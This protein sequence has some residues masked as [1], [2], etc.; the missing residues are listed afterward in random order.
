MEPD[1]IADVYEISSLEQL[2]TIAD[3]LRMRVMDALTHRAMTVTQLGELLGE[4]PAKMHYHVRGLERVGLVRLVATREKG[5][6]LEKYYRAVARTF[7]TNDMLLRA[8][9]SDEFLA[10]LRSFLERTTESF[11]TATIESLRRYGGDAAKASGGLA[12]AQLWLTPEEGEQFI[13]EIGALMDRYAAPRGIEGEQERTFVWLAYDPRLVA[14]AAE[15]EAQPAQAA[16]RTAR[17]VV[18]GA[19][20]YSRADLEQVLARGERLDLNVVGVC[21]FAADVPPELVDRA[22]A[23]FR[24]RGG[25]HA[26]ESVREVLKGKEQS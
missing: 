18:V 12:G 21:T 14:P 26:S 1:D 4:S 24:Y 23:R 6:I 2:R 16:P 15:P 7:R 13:K 8:G 3:E 25:L 19:A 10:P 17:A 5:G 22:I 20:H 11:L 9:V